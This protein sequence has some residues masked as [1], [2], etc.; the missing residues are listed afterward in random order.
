MLTSIR[1][2]PKI[3]CGRRFAVVPEIRSGFIIFAGRWSDCFWAVDG[4]RFGLL[5]KR[6]LSGSGCS[7]DVRA[8]VRNGLAGIA[9]TDPSHP[10][11]NFF[12]FM[13]GVVLHAHAAIGLDVVVALS[14]APVSLM[15]TGRSGM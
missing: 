7:A 14:V 11:K 1:S 4:R 12:L 3:L 10:F 8:I 13:A 15:F 9:G 2:R 5:V 6:G